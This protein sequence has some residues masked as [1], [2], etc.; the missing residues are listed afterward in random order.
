MKVEKHQ[1]NYDKVKIGNDQLENVFT[2]TYLGAEIPGDGD[3]LIPI[4]HRC[5]VT[6]GCIGD[7]RKT[8]DVFKAPSCY[9]QPPVRIPGLFNHD[10]RM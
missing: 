3:P 9:A 4:K 5:D 8:L 7:Y 1:D 10:L 6:W 2:F